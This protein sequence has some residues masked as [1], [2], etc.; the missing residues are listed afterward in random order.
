MLNINGA[1]LVLGFNDSQP[2][3]M[4]SINGAPL[5]LGFNDSQPLGVHLFILNYFSELL[6]EGDVT[7]VVFHIL[8]QSLS[9]SMDVDIPW[10][11]QK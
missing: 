7:D 9:S 8:P 4:L 1:P 6:F 11:C 3:I 10:T 5:V 2:L